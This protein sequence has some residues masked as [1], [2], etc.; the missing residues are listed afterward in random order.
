MISAK[1]DE[2]EFVRAYTRKAL[3]FLL[4]MIIF[5]IAI[6]AFSA[7]L[8]FQSPLRGPLFLC[9]F[10]PLILFSWWMHK[11]YPPVRRWREAWLKEHQVRLPSEVDKEKSEK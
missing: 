8:P 4:F 11:Q 5:A 6:A 2:P 1:D 7:L 9:P 3:R 10:I